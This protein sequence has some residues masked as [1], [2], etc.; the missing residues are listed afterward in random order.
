MRRRCFAGD[1]TRFV[2]PAFGAYTSSLNVL[3][4]AY[5][6]LFNRET[7]MVLLRPGGRGAM[8]HANVHDGAITCP[9]AFDDR[10][11]WAGVGSG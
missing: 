4:R 7:L 8:F 6:G 1:G 3:D 11:V 5:Q 2:I 9:S 10:V